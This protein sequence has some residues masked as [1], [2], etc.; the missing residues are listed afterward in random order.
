MDGPHVQFLGMCFLKCLNSCIII[1]THLHATICYVIA[2]VIQEHF[3]GRLCRVSS[4]CTCSGEAKHNFD[5][6]RLPS[7]KSLEHGEAR[8]ACLYVHFSRSVV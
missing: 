7:P 3:Q 2:L 1:Y 5:K 4:M 8:G 6:C